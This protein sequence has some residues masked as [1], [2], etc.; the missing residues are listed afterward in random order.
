MRLSWV[1]GGGGG[2]TVDKASVPISVASKLIGMTALLLG[3]Q[4]DNEMRVTA[5][6]EG[7]PDTSTNLLNTTDDDY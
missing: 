4:E 7:R 3:C 6:C 1:K 5:L 2:V